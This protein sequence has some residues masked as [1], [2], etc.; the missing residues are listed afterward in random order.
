MSDLPRPRRAA[1]GSVLR[2]R[3]LLYGDTNIGKTHQYFNLALWHQ[4]L[5]SPAH[6]YGVSTDGSWE[7]LMD[8]EEF[9]GLTN[10]SWVEVNSF[11]E[12]LDAVKQAHAKA[13]RNVD[14][15]C[16]DLHNQSWS[17]AQDEY[18]AA[19]AKGKN[20][21]IE[22]IGDLWK[23]EGPGEYPIGGWEWG[24]PNARY[25]ILANNYIIRFPGH[26]F[27]ISGE[28]TLQDESSKGDNEFQRKQRQTF[29]HVGSLPE[30]Q[31]HDPFMFRTVLNL[32]GMGPKQQGII[33][34]KET[35]GRRRFMGKSIGRNATIMRPEKIEDFFMDYMVGVAGWEMS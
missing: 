23:L 15:L 6:F 28:K 9:E 30:G 27:M 21:D 1:N 5:G 17:W 7:W 14:W 10:I 24:M 16:G 35:S 4:N 8:N 13:Q 18:A 22:D 31:K 19:Q 33:T 25:R 32:Q 11:Q 29:K 12:Y 20:H 26:V 2:E 3:I 34:A